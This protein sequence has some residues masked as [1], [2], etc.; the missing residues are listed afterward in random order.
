MASAPFLGR[1]Q[2]LLSAIQLAEDLAHGL[3]QPAGA[4]A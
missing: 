1:A 3:R 4:P 2:A